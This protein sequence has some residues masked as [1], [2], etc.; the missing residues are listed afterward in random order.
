M[1]LVFVMPIYGR[2]DLVRMIL[3][4]WHYQILRLRGTV[5]VH[6]V[7]IGSEGKESAALL[8]G[9]SGDTMS[10][11]EAPN[12]PLN[13]KWNAGLQVARFLN[14]DGVAIVGSD[15]LVSDS[16]LLAWSEK[17]SQGVDLFGLKD[18]Y[19]FDALSLRLGY[20]PGY[21]TKRQ[22]N[23]KGEPVGLGRCHSRAVME[24]VG[25][26]LWPH[27]PE[28]NSVLD[29]MSITRL[30]EHGY[31]PVAFS[32]GELN[33]KAVD[34]KA[35]LSITAFDRIPYHH[36]VKGAKAMEYLADLVDDDGLAMLSTKWRVAA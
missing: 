8:S 23:R 21:G 1:K 34:I 15:D 19:F 2:H 14:P 30:R 33:A 27:D 18:L 26:Q 9:Y 4:Q 6:V 29:L 7:C 13:R 10:Y 25:W 11:V 22:P 36:T 20:W 3:R 5:D 31:E 32:L 35:G 12:T 28:R 17:L 24:A 16:L